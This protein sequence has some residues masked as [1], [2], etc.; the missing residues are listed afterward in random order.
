MIRLLIIADDFTGALDTGVQF[1]A[2]G[3]VTRVI[4]DRTAELACYADCCEVLVVD[5]ETRHLRAEQAYAIVADIVS[6][7]SR[8]GIR[9]IFKK[10]DSALRGNIGAEL[11]ALLKASGEAQLPFLPAFPQMNRRTVK[12]VH[13]IGDVPVAQSVFGADPFEPVIH[14][15]VSRIIAQQ[16]DTQVTCC[17]AMAAEDA[18]CEAPGILVYDASSLEDLTATARCLQETDK[19]HILAGCAGIASVLPK[20]LQLG[21]GEPVPMPALDPNFLVICGSVNPITVAQADRAEEE[22]FLRIRLIP[23]QKLEPEHWVTREGEMEFQALYNIL[24]QYPRR[25]IDTNDF[26]SNKPTADYAAAHGMTTEDVRQAVSRSIGYLVSRL[27]PNPNLG[28]LLITGGDTLLQCMDYMNIREIEP[29]RELD[30]G[31]VLSRF[32]YQ[33]FTRYVISKSGGFGKEDLFVKLS[34]RIAHSIQKQ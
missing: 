28:T 8:L 1:A 6:K 15:E 21:T 2:C 24:N 23:E 20:L 16:S 10:T 33:G 29:L 11:T 4:T 14:S 26:G 9:H 5:A 7:A 25:I 12:G 18:C 17:E 13:Y 34:E 32:T 31:V 22:G 19:L 30:S 3:A 27:F